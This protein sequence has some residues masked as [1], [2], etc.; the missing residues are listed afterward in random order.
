MKVSHLH[1]NHSASRRNSK[2]SQAPGA[3]AVLLPA[4]TP[5][6]STAPP[7]ARPAP[8]PCG[9][10]PARTSRVASTAT[11]RSR[12]TVASG[13]GGRSLL[14]PGPG[15]TAGPRTRERRVLCP[16]P[17]PVR[18][19]GP[20]TASAYSQGPTSA[21]PHFPLH[22][23][24]VASVP[25]T[26]RRPAGHERSPRSSHRPR[27][28]QRPRAAPVHET[29]AA[30]RSG[31]H[32]ARTAYHRHTAGIT[33]CHYRQPHENLSSKCRVKVTGSI[34]WSSGG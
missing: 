1:T 31:P 3:V 17:P 20:Q 19:T 15:S 14:G 5:P 2:T 12:S 24:T 13:T 25:P 9:P 10:G 34:G 26:V 27:T 16:T 8:A 4:A 7:R 11:T 28:G 6:A 30:Q 18:R 32:P 23:K 21:G 29:P 22:A 33:T